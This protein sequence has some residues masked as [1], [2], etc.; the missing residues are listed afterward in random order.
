MQVVL[1]GATSDAYLAVAFAKRIMSNQNLVMLEEKAM[2]EDLRAVVDGLAGIMAKF[3][4]DLEMAM[5]V[6]TLYL[7]EKELLQK[8][9]DL[10]ETT[11][12]LKQAIEEIVG[13]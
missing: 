9:N 1:A 12:E 11:E 10:K 4:C 7:D 13:K 5:A 8:E 6:Y 2:N 3:N